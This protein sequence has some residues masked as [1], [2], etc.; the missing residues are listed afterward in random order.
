[1]KKL[2]VLLVIA[3][4]S[5]SMNV[6][7]QEAKPAAPKPPAPPAAGAP[8]KPNMPAAGQQ[9]PIEHFVHSTD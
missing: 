9:Q 1:M 7:A 3:T 2:I 6:H 4:L 8:A 5:L